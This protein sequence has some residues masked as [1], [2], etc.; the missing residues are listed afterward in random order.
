MRNAFTAALMLAGALSAQDWDTS[1]NSLL[2]GRY[3]FRQVVWNVKDSTGD[4]ARSVAITGSIEFNGSG[5]YRLSATVVDSISPR[6]QSLSL[7]GFYA[8][9]ASGY[10]FLT[11]PASSGG[12]VYGG[13]A[14]GIFVGSSTE[15]PL[16]DLFVAAPAGAS[17]L[18]GRYWVAELN[19]P[20]L[21]VNQ[22]RDAF[23]QLNANGQGG[24]ATIAAT[25][26]IGG[27]AGVNQNVAGASYS[28]SGDTGT[29]NF[30]GT[31]SNQNLLA[32][33]RTFFLSPDGNLLFG[34]SS[35]G[36]SFL[37]GVRALD[38]E[39]AAST[40]DGLYFTAGTDVN[41]RNL[42]SGEAAVN[43]Y[44]G[45]SRSSAGSVHGHQRLLTQF[46]S[47]A[48]PYDFTY[49][50]SYELDARGQYDDYLGIR[51][52]VGAG[53][54]IRIGYGL[55]YSPGISV[56]VRLPDLASDGV[57]LNPASVVNA[58]SFA[59][60]TQG[61]APGELIQFT[62]RNLAAAEASDST[63]PNTLGG[64][65]VRINGRLAPIQSVSPEKITAIVPFGTAE[66]IA[67]I[68]V[69]NETGESNV[70][71]AFVNVSAPGVFT[72]PAGGSGL[73]DAIHGDGSPVTKDNPA[74]LGETITMRVTGLGTVSPAVP[75]AAP[76]PSAPASGA[77]ASTAVFVDGVRAEV[78][79]AGLAP[80]VVG[81]YQVTFQVPT[82]LDPG[83]LYV[84]VSGPDAYSTQAAIPVERAL[85]DRTL[86][87]VRQGLRSAAGRGRGL[88]SVQ[89][90]V[91]VG[92]RRSR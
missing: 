51:H 55:R 43:S 4:L 33:R 81:L 22:V 9:S 73:A 35:D 78:S 13:V 63:F 45:A 79:F 60:F 14:Q 8:I 92:K 80:G 42:A 85:G 83:D 3:N 6:E 41:T 27:G 28:F 16:T 69:V 12:R 54:A 75:D 84:D 40:M 88:Q 89:E 18:N 7:D 11:N 58:A 57:F 10:G 52:A 2:Q 32:G 68:Q 67:R 65:Q 15:E 24:L 91:T 72:V 90:R 87:P 17:A 46:R 36:W 77:V 50:D 1:G 38:G 34:G 61:I 82:G 30:G 5:Q 64:V 29:L 19:F 44:Y 71:T 70:V 48:S 37:V 86:M 39:A 21:S 47:N 23:F 76:G 49:S 59:P 74:R 53:G 26:F 62:G 31:L 20:S 56:A 25:G 66:E